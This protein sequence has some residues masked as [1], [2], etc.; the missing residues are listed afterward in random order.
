MTNAI[1]FSNV[2]KWYG[3]FQALNAING[4]VMAGQTVVLCGASGSGKS[5]LLRT[6]NRLEQ[7]QHGVVEV[8]GQNVNDRQ[9]NINQV[10]RDI[11]FVF[12]QFNLFP[13][14][15]AIANVAL[16]LRRVL[17]QSK[18]TA[19]ELAREA[20]ESVGLS[21]RVD[22]MPAD[23]S[24]GEEQRVAIARTLVQDP[25]VILLDE[26]TSALDPEKVGEVLT[27]MHKL[28]NSKRT[29]MCVTHEMGFARKAAD[30]VWFMEGGRIAESATPET[31]FSA[32]S[33]PQA[34]QFLSRI[35]PH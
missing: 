15:S 26:P 13:H 1:V 3:A 34:R 33:T 30:V 12:Q 9:A 19:Y 28:S 23:L 20:L 35:L 25:S 27:I 10:R 22:Y 7:I 31:F 6:I 8:N 2:S 32:P 4:I 29:I 14:L 24:G 21:H 16:P 5:T 11:G 18:S 17:G